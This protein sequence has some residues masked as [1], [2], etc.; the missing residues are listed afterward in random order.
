MRGG[1]TPGVPH[2][3]ADATEGG[4]SSVPYVIGA[5]PVLY[6][7]AAADIRRSP[8]GDTICH[9]ECHACVIASARV[10][11]AMGE[12]TGAVKAA[13]RYAARRRDGSVPDRLLAALRDRRTDLETAR[14][15]LAEHHTREHLLGAL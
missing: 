9:R 8:V 2:H 6:S 5:R 7:G 4:S 1:R 11:Y 13:N 3:R 12:L 14:R 10:S 15:N